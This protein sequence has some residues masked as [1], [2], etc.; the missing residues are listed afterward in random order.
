MLITSVSVEVFVPIMIFVVILVVAVTLVH[1]IRNGK[2]Q[3][4]GNGD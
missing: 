1:L 4:Y 2:I 3:W